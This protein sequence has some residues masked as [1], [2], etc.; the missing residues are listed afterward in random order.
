MRLLVCSGV[1]LPAEGERRG[2]AVLVRQRAAD[3]RLAQGARAGHPGPRGQRAV[4][5]YLAMAELA[6]FGT[7]DAFP[8]PSSL[9]FSFLFFSSPLVQLA[10]GGGVQTRA[11]A[12]VR[13]RSR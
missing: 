13:D 5:K 6:P 8:P 2:A 4:R 11:F 1:G 7:T 12:F 10:T 3:A 9:F